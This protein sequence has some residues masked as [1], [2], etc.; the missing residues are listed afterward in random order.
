VQ[1]RPVEDYYVNTNWRYTGTTYTE[2]DNTRTS[3]PYNL[4][5]LK[6]GYEM[7]AWTFNVFVTNVF[8]ERYVTGRSTSEGSVEL[9]DPRVVGM[10][11][12]LDW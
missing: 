2:L 7:D 12:T 1:Y 6:A 4:V 8:D 5:D 9:G 10:N 3:D 11:V